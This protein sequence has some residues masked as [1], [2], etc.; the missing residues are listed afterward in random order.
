MFRS[1]WHY[2]LYFYPMKAEIISIGDELLIGQTI[3]TN[4]GWM[5]QQLN[6][7][8]AGLERVITISDSRDAILNTLK[9]CLNRADVV[10]ITGG[11]GPTKDDITKHTLCEFFHTRLVR[12]AE[13]LARVEKFFLKRGRTMLESNR[14]QADLPEDCTVLPNDFGTASGMWFEKDGKIVVSLPGVPYEMKHLMEMQVI[15]RLKTRFSLP[16]IVHRT[17]MTQGIGESFLAEM[18]SNW[19]TELRNAGLSL[20][21]LPSPGIVKLRI[22]GKGPDKEAL[23]KKTL[24][25]E[26]RLLPL[27]EKFHFGFDND[28]LETTL[29]DLLREKK[30]SL[31][32]AESCTGGY[33]AHRITSIPGSSD[34]FLGSVISYSNAVKIEQLGVDSTDLNTHGAVSPE[35]VEQMAKGVIKKLHARCSIAVSGVA[36]PDGGSDEKPVGTVWIAVAFDDRVVSRKFLFEQNRERNITRSALTGMMMLRQ[37]ILGTI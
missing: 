31:V 3:N 1:R 16:V 35:V 34:Y 21:Y 26:Q 7:I 28:L 32:T 27:I 20:A 11:L 23:E 29:G 33:I 36:G 5:G 19:E 2:A 24:E 8:G 30:L 10:L 6:L 13:V 9:D 22:T 15:P 18:I 4:A 37:L 25:F 12:N 17:I 14:Q